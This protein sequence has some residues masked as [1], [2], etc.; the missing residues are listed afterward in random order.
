MWGSRF[1][2][3]ALPKRIDL[4][5]FDGFTANTAK[6]NSLGSCNEKI[7]LI[8]S[9]AAKIET[10]NTQPLIAGICKTVLSDIN[11]SY[12]KEFRQA[13]AAITQAQR[14]WVGKALRDWNSHLDGLL[15]R[16][17]VEIK[18]YPNSGVFDLRTF[19]LRRQMEGQ[20]RRARWAGRSKGNGVRAWLLGLGYGL[21][22][23]VALGLRIVPTPKVLLALLKA[24]PG[25]TTAVCF[26]LT[27]EA[28]LPRIVDQLAE[29]SAP[30]A[31]FL[32][33]GQPNVPGG[34]VAISR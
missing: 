20:Q 21:L 32:L 25:W 2:G 1:K 30:N 12:L 15:A 31:S 34:N 8:A 24:P 29:V 26:R 27:F 9:N 11:S 28:A 17:A 22:S 18:A 23:R 10:F 6:I 16:A 5:K 4:P 3:I 19:L 14:N 7:N 13:S 33:P